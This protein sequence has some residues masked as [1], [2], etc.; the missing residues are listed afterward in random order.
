MKVAVIGGGISGLYSANLLCEKGYDVEIYEGGHWGGDIQTATIENV[1]YP[2]STLFA[3]PDDDILKGEF[4]KYNI[5]KGS[6]WSPYN[7]PIMGFLIFLFGIS[8]GCSILYNFKYLIGSIILLILLIIITYITGCSVL[9]GFGGDNKCGIKKVMTSIP[10]VYGYFDTF[11]LM[12]DCEFSKLCLGYLNNPK[13]SY[14]SYGVNNVQYNNGQYTVIANNNKINKFDKVII[15]CG[16]ESY[17]KIM[18]LTQEEKDILGK[19]K[20]FNFYTT[21]VKP[22]DNSK[23]NMNFSNINGSIKLKDAM[24]FGSDKPLNISTKDKIVKNFAWK[25]PINIGDMRINQKRK[26]ILNNKVKN[27]YFIGKEMTDL[28]GVNYCMKYAKEIIDKY[29]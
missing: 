26:Q 23:N 10:Y 17:S 5:G 1:C 7:K 20:Y 28:N 13:I 24:L 22:N 15:A 19:T 14:V 25:M 9:L 27:V 8:L 11:E 6:N 16:Y 3:M 2:V 21:L 29:F 4:K 12:E 18:N